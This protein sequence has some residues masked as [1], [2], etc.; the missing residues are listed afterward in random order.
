MSFEDDMK[1]IVK[2]VDAMGDA[3]DV[4]ADALGDIRLGLHRAFD[5]ARA[6]V[7]AARTFRRES[8][9][10]QERLSQEWYAEHPNAS[11]FERW[12]WRV[13]KT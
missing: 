3:A 13:P 9:Q 1:A 5:G 7:Q 2:H 8:R 11:L 6:Y 4:I 12:L 10:M